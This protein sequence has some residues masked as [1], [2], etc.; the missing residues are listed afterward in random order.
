M[1]RL[2]IDHLP[3]LHVLEEMRGDLPRLAL[4][5]RA[6]EAAD[7]RRGLGAA[8]ELDDARAPQLLDARA[9]MRDAHRRLATEEERPDPEL[10][11]IVSHLLEHAA[12]AERVGRRRQQHGRM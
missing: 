7:M 9:R 11:R 5:V 4:R 3:D 1:P 6:G 2:G 10:A 12:E 8:I